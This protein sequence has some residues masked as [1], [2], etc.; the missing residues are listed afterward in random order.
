MTSTADNSV[1][2]TVRLAQYPNKAPVV[3]VDLTNLE[4]STD[5]KFRINLYGAIG[6]NCANVGPEFNPMREVNRYN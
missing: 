3:K 2:G 5:Y 4:A 6:D 1:S